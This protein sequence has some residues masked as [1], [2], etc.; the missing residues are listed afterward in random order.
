MADAIARDRGRF[1]RN[2]VVQGTAAEW[3]ECW[4]ADLRGRL[5]RISAEGLRAELVYFL[6][7]EVVVHAEEAAAAA[8]AAAVQDAA[9]AAGTLLF[10]GAPVG[11]PLSV[12]VVDRTIRQ[13]R[14]SPDVTTTG[15]PGY[16]HNARRRRIAF[17]CTPTLVGTQDFLGEGVSR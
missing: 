16:P 10:P 17:R 7:D 15:P 4:M 9:D 14:P 13:N 11:F 2:F 1:T 8:C 6:H 3:A 12:A 5:R